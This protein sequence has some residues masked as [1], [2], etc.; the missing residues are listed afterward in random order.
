MT[1]SSRFV[2]VL[3]L[4]VSLPGVAVWSAAPSEAALGGFCAKFTKLV[5]HDGNKTSDSKSVSENVKILKAHVANLRSSNPPK[6]WKNVID[7]WVG[8]NTATIAKFTGKTSVAHFGAAY[9][10]E[11][12]KSPLWQKY[13]TDYLAALSHCT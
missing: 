13:Q 9:D 10:D 11:L 2:A 7:E 12:T 3:S 1:R 4:A 6:D 5:F 8:A